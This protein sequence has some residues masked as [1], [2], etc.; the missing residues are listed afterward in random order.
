M[1]QNAGRIRWQSHSLG[2]VHGHSLSCLQLV[3]GMGYKVHG[4]LAP[5]AW[6]TWC[7]SSGFP[8]HRVARSSILTACSTFPEPKQ[9]TPGVSRAEPGTCPDHFCLIR[10]RGGELDSSS[11]WEEEWAL[12]E[13]RNRWWSCLETILSCTLYSGCE[14]DSKLER[15]FLEP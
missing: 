9:K 4:G 7:L 2:P 8:L 11:C 6:A 14:H 10:D 12:R 3:V 1:A 15:K 13:C 5:S